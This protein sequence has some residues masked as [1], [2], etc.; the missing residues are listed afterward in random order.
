MRKLGYFLLCRKDRLEIL[1]D[2]HNMQASN[3]T[4]LRS[5]K[6]SFRN[7]KYAEIDGHWLSG[8]RHWKGFNE[9]CL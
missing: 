3:K 4:T 5:T 2:V 9:W 6:F 7:R 1:N 8:R